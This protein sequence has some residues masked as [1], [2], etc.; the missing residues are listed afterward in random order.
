MGGKQHSCFF[1]RS[2]KTSGIVRYDILW[3]IFDVP[4]YFMLRMYNNTRQLDGRKRK[5]STG[6]VV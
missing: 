1:G 6:T 3:W 4:V 5:H 2:I